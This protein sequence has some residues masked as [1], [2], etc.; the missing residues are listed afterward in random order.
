[1]E[2]AV[3]IK[4]VPDTA[5]PRTLDPHTGRITRDPSEAV[6][7]EISERALEKALQLRKANGGEVTVI[8]MGPEKAVAAL[9]HALAMGADRAVHLSD[10]S[11]AGADLVRTAQ[12]LA[13]GI[14]STGPF[15]LIIAGNAST[16]G[17]GGAIPAMLAEL[18]D[19]A[20]ATS[21]QAFDVI[22]GVLT[23]ERVLEDSIQR[24]QA[25]LPAVVSVTEQIAE[26][27]YPGFKGIMMAKRKKILGLDAAALAGCSPAAAG[28]LIGTNVVRSVS[29]NPS[30]TSGEKFADDGFAGVRI[31]DYITAEGLV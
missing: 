14:H 22:G 5:S 20:Q 24:I 27:R 26:P 4:Q 25:T 1:M 28:G 3:L 2:I 6:V 29:E 30:R 19:V 10:E 21:L 8:A 15:D 16:D 12:L 17:R 13:T 23:G 31:S 18:L 9:R 11:F 7:D